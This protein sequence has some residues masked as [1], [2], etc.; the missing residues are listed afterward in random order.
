[1]RAGSAERIEQAIRGYQDTAIL[2]AAIELD[3]P[4]AIAAGDTHVEDLAATVRC[5]PQRLSR[6]LRALV[7]MDMCEQVGPGRF[8]L[9][10]A[11]RGFLR[12]SPEPHRELVG[13]AVDQYW[14]AWAN[15]AHSIRTGESAFVHVHGDLPFDWRQAHPV[16]D[17]QFATWLS[18]ETSRAAVSIASCIDLSPDHTVADVGGGHGALLLALLERHPLAHGILV[19]QRAVV[20]RAAAQWPGELT[21][22][23]G[24]VAA[25]FFEPL[26]VSADVIV[27]KSV[28]HDWPDD[29]A[30][31][32]LRHCAAPMSAGSRLV[33]VERLLDDPDTD[34]QGVV[35][36]D[37]HMMA[38]TGG[39][40]RTRAE[41]EQLIVGA[42][43]AVDRIASTETGF[44]I[45]ETRRP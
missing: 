8:E 11:G 2:H 39:R 30:V 37:L 28:L 45:V 19:D 5:D 44:A 35:R 15:L 26:P 27:L 43:L 13:L 31:S 6:L 7:L 20:E 4:D 9:T 12:T 36:L 34:P 24:F 21:S 1:M 29:Q 16:A 33:I 41:Y 32:I 25:D 14:S 22:R 40:E 42:G 38:V 3:L 17:R 10:E 18:K 23:T